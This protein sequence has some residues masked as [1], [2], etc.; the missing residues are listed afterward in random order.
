VEK[1]VTAAIAVP[2]IGI[3]RRSLR[4]NRIP[5]HLASRCPILMVEIYAKCLPAA[6]R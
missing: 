1:I 6:E 4:D 5:P 3:E 2:T